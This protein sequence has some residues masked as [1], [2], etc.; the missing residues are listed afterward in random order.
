MLNML[1][2]FAFVSPE[3]IDIANERSF[4]STHPF[5]KT[6]P[7]QNYSVIQIRHAV[8]Y[9]IEFDPKCCCDNGGRLLVESGEN[10]TRG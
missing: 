3:G 7:A 9:V 2:H 1:D 6:I 10:Q 5:T 4:E 8:G